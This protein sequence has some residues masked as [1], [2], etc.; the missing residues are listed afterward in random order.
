MAPNCL[1]HQVNFLMIVISIGDTVQIKLQS[2]SFSDYGAVTGTVSYI[3]PSAIKMEG[4]GNVY[5][6]RAQID[7]KLFR[8]DYWWT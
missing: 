6:V 1:V 2:Y 5:I 8:T 4:V 7:K 3:S